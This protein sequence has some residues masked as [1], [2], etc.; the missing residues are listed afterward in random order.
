MEHHFQIVHVEKCSKC[1]K[2]FQSKG[3]LNY[4]VEQA[5]TV[6]CSKCPKRFISKDLYKTH[7]EIDHF[8]KCTKCPMKFGTMG[9]INHHFQVIHH[10]DGKE[11]VSTINNDRNDRKPNKQNIPDDN[12]NMDIEENED[13]IKVMAETEMSK[14]DSKEDETEM[15]SKAS[16]INSTSGK[17]IA[18]NVPLDLSSFKCNVCNKSF[19]NNDKLRQHMEGVHHKLQH[20]QC[21]DS[22]SSFSSK[23]KFA[24]HRATVHQGLK[25]KCKYCTRPFRNRWVLKLHVTKSHGDM[26]IKQMPTM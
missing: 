5:H 6:Q 1:P 18:A 14:L 22:E 26:L 10:T 12:D 24:N 20:F 23:K 25:F 4:H 15:V 2:S 8:V 11:I 13:K 21:N 3:E 7:F 9:Q 16:N 17:S 19:Q